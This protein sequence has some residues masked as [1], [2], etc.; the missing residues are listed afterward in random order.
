[1]STETD[2]NSSDF[3]EPFG[4]MLLISPWLEYNAEAPSFE[5]NSTR[6]I[7][8]PHAWQVFS[9][10]VKQLEGIVPALHNHL[11][12]GITPRLVERTRAGIPA[13]DYHQE[14]M[15]ASLI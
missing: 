4:G 13:R 6:D 12:P 1:M 8:P 10:I 7:L 14:N 9:D 5:R 11:E 2:V 15:R 3:P